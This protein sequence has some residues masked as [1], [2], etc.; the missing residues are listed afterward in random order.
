MCVCVYVCGAHA[1]VCGVC[2]RACM[3]VCACL[4]ACVHACMCCQCMCA[5]SRVVIECMY[6]QD[7]FIVFQ[8][9]A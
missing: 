2:V 7:L 4:R 1:C 8:G 6:I 5:N 3:C 9:A